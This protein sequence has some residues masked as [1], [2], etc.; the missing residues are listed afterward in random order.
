MCTNH[1]VTLDVVGKV[2]GERTNVIEVEEQPT[3]KSGYWDETH[4]VYHGY[5]QSDG[6]TYEVY[7]HVSEHDDTNGYSAFNENTIENLKYIQN[8]EYQSDGRGRTAGVFHGEQN[9][10]DIE[11]RYVKD[12][13]TYWI[14]RE[15]ENYQYSSEE[16]LVYVNPCCEAWT[17][18]IKK[19]II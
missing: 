7:N 5:Y 17:K 10:A 4:G 18:S 16:K 12:A 2:V 19:C 1:N 14:S 3:K 6:K 11:Y 8:F 13:N 15:F 9:L